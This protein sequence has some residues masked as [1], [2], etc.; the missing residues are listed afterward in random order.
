MQWSGWK[1]VV[2]SNSTGDPRRSELDANGLVNK[3]GKQCRGADLLLS[4]EVFLGQNIGG[5]DFCLLFSPKVSELAAAT[6]SEYKASDYD[7]Q[8][9]LHQHRSV[10]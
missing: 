7:G 5:G 3:I 4:G 1:K 8:P 9:A 10:H 6:L 2:I